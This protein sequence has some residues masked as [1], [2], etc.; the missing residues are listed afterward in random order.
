MLS[1]LRKMLRPRVS[2]SLYEKQNRA[3]IAIYSG[4]STPLLALRSTWSP[5]LPNRVAPSHF[6]T[7]T[8]GI[9]VSFSHGHIEDLQGSWVWTV[10]VFEG[11]F[12]AGPGRTASGAKMDKY[13]RHRYFLLSTQA[14]RNSS[15]TQQWG[16]WVLLCNSLRQR[17]AVTG[18]AQNWASGI[19]PSMRPRWGWGQGGLETQPDSLPNSVYCTDSSRSGQPLM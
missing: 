3:C 9:K 1:S 19:I 15:E 8:S 7:D 5:F 2:V 11:V 12:T 18:R 16:L 6:P 4:S 17:Q 13:R 10:F 14:T